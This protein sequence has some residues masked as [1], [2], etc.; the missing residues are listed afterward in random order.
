[1]DIKELAILG[2]NYLLFLVPPIALF[3]FWRASIEHR[4]TLLLRGIIV[5]IIGVIL[6]KLGGL[7]YYE[8]RPFVVNHIHPLIPH[9]DDNGFP[10]D[11]TLAISAIAL[12]LAPFSLP[13]GGVTLLIA[14]L[15][16]IS[17]MVCH[18]H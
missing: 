12:L 8:P 17:R 10:S 1:M 7:A 6:A 18:L 15:V 3:V 9:A 13:A 11:H 4:K 14:V 2:A 5:L 16:G